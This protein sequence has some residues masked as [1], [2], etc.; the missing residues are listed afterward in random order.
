MGASFSIAT[1][2]VGRH[3]LMNQLIDLPTSKALVPAVLQAVRDL[4]GSAKSK[5]IDSFVIEALN[6][7]PALASVLH[8]GDGSKRTELQ[9]R[10]AWSRNLAKR[11]GELLRDSTG[12]WELTG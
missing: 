5:E 11:S 1:V 9:Y 3:E 6:L 8:K 12:N 4:G 2:L 7:P 10:L